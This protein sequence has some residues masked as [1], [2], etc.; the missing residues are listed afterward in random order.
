MKYELSWIDTIVWKD[1]DIKNNEFQATHKY[2]II[3]IP[4]K[5]D[6]FILFIVQCESNS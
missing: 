2:S 6:I 3:R 5:T 1:N 4:E